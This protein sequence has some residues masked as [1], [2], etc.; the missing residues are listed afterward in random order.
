VNGSWRK[1][2]VGGMLEVPEQVNLMVERFLAIN[3]L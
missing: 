1:R 3:H 2:F